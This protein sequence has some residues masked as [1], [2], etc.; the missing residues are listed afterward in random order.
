MRLRH[1]TAYPAPKIAHHG[2]LKSRA[3]GPI[4]ASDKPRAPPFRLINNTAPRDIARSVRQQRQASV[5]A[6]ALYAAADERAREA[7][8]AG[9]QAKKD[10][11]PANTT[12][13]YAS[14]QR[15]WKVPPLCI[16]CA[17]RTRDWHADTCPRTSAMC[18]AGRR[19]A[20]C[21][22]GLTASLSRQ[23]SWRRGSRRTSSCGA[24]RPI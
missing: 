9:L 3:R 2:T 15:E 14:K 23:T 19:T 13:S 17:P 7:Y 6:S 22:A 24:F 16:P 1:V 5:M 11:Q 18:R 20:P 4:S 10:E 8:R 21:I 12:R